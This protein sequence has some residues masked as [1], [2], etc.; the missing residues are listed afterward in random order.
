VDFASLD[1]AEYC[2]DEHHFLFVPDAQR[3]VERIL[4]EAWILQRVSEC[5]DLTEGQLAPQL[6]SATTAGSHSFEGTALCVSPLC[7]L[8]KGAELEDMALSMNRLY[9]RHL[10]SPST[11]AGLLSETC[12][13]LLHLC[14]RLLAKFSR[15][16]EA[17]EL[18]LCDILCQWFSCGFAGVLSQ[19]NYF[20]LWDRI[21]FLDSLEP[22]A[23]MAAAVLWS[24]SGTLL[25]LSNADDIDWALSNLSGIE[26]VPLLQS[27]LVELAKCAGSEI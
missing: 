24:L 21:L 27:F 23:L 15:L 6:S 18:S 26:T 14:P 4:L 9:Y 8:Y 5:P 13:V 7:F 17:K 12:Y 1:A 25:G 22:L 11:V 16:E 2:N 19:R 10:H 20:A 3:L